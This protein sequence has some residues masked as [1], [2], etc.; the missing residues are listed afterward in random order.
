MEGASWA[1]HHRRKALDVTPCCSSKRLHGHWT[2]LDQSDVTGQT[3]EY[4]QYYSIPDCWSRVCYYIVN[5]GRV[6]R[7]W[8]KTGTIR[9]KV[10]CVWFARISLNPMIL[11]LWCEHC[12]RH[13]SI[14]AAC[15]E[16]TVVKHLGCRGV[17]S[18]FSWG[19][20]FF[21]FFNATGLLKN[22]KKQHCICSN[23]ALFIVLF[24][25]FS[26]FFL[27][28]LFFLRIISFFLFPWVGRGGDDHPSPPQMTPLLG[29][30]GW[31]GS[32][33]VWTSASWVASLK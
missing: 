2:T 17:I 9:L 27:F 6:E 1:C 11:Q 28:F 31:V 8:W 20:N 15:S 4:E 25:H 23:L 18:T 3:V 14:R 33:F 10:L 7:T 21:K 32:L 26:S 24:F 19:P 22:C 16:K 12:G 29:W 13:C 30:P 5:H